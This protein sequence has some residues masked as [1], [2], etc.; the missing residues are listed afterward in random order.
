MASV[1]GAGVG[2]EVLALSMLAILF[3]AICA[4]TPPGKALR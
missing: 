4:N 3:F 2:A 1:C